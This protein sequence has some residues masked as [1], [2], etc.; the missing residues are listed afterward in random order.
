MTFVVALVAVAVT[1]VERHARQLLRIGAP[2]VASRKNPD[3][4]VVTAAICALPTRRLG[5]RCSSG[6]GDCCCA[7]L[8]VADASGV[9][10]AAVPAVVTTGEGDGDS[11]PVGMTEGPGDAVGLGDA[12]TVAVCDGVGEPTGSSAAANG[13]ATRACQGFCVSGG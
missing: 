7:G 5:D 10:L 8:G 2:V 9:R 4:V 13:L 6:L 1:D 3:V 12:A 11:E